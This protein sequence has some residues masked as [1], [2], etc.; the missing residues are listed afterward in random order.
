MKQSIYISLGVVALMGLIP[1]TMAQA[2]FGIDP[3]CQ[4]NASVTF[5]ESVLTVS[6]TDDS[7]IKIIRSSLDLN[8]CFGLLDNQIVPEAE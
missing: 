8:H 6:C 3:R 7:D 2:Y 1:S 5:D 4:N